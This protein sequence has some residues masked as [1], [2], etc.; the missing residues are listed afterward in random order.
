[1]PLGLAEYQ[2]GLTGPGLQ[3][4]LRTFRTHRNYHYRK[5]HLAALD[6]QRYPGKIPNA[7]NRAAI[8][9]ANDYD[10]LVC[11]KMS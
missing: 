2:G 6:D 10:Y 9:R 4:G 5:C 7:V 11:D 3:S 1:V 8:A